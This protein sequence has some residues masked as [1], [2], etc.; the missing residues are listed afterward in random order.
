MDMHKQPPLRERY[1][2]IDFLYYTSLLAVPV[3]TAFY[4]ISRDSTWWLIFYIFLCI[5]ATA[6]IYRF[7]CS[8][9]PH[10]TREERTTRCMFFWGL[11]KFFKPHPGP[12]SFLDKT[13]ACISPAAVFIFPLYWLFQHMGLLIIFAFS[14][15]AF[16]ATV[17]RNECRRCIYFNCPANTVPEDLKSHDDAA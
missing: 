2:F 7:Y 16:I 8:H 15:V 1:T 9:C 3:F 12:L 13:L 4:A 17:R 11:P 5:G 14:L 6:V 10:Y